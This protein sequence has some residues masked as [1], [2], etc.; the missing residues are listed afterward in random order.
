MCLEA[1]VII[2]GGNS[3]KTSWEEI[4]KYNYKYIYVLF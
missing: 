4:K 1:L 3:K 2:V